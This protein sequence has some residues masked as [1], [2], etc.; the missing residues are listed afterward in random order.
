MGDP[1]RSSID[2]QCLQATIA[3]VG[4]ATDIWRSIEY[5]SS[6]GRPAP[7]ARA[8]EAF[9]PHSPFGGSGYGSLPRGAYRLVVSDPGTGTNFWTRCP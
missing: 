8:G 4:P 6:L 1:V 3:N 2:H 9:C 5:T 7:A